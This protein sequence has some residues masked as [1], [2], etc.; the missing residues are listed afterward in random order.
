MRGSD[1]FENAAGRWSAEQVSYKTDLITDF[2]T[3]F[4]REAARK[5]EPFFLYVSEYAPHWPLHAK[6]E[7]MEKYRERYRRL[8]WDEHGKNR[9]ERLQ[10]EGLIPTGMQLP[11]RDPRA[12]PG[13]RCRRKTGRDRMAAYA[14]LGV[15]AAWTRASEKFWKR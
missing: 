13:I 5:E 3:G 11:P 15:D 14:A 2:A 7:D 9:P 12:K 1:F 4:I 10:R 6:R 8:G